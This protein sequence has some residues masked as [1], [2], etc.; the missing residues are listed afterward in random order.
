MGQTVSSWTAQEDYEVVP[1]SNIANT[2]FSL[3][4]VAV[5]KRKS[6]LINCPFLCLIFVKLLILIWKTQQQQKKGF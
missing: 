4:A 2:Q 1:R 6:S 5:S 3:L